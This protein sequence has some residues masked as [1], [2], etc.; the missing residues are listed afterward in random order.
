MRV[1]KSDDGRMDSCAHI[2]FIMTS[3]ETK[4]SYHIYNNII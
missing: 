2:I 3:R 4:K 1:K